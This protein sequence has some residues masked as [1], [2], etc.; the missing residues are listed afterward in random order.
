MCIIITVLY[1]AYN[2][3]NIKLNNRE[4][5]LHS[6]FSNI[7]D[8]FLVFDFMNKRYEYISPNLENILG[9]SSS[10]LS[11]NIFALFDNVL[12]EQKA[13]FI[14]LFSSSDVTKFKERI[15]EYYHPVTKQNRWL[16]MRNYPIDQENNI[17]RYIT[18]IKDITKEFQEQSAIREALSDALKA[19][20]SKTEFMCHMSHEIKTPINSILGLTQIVLNSLEDRDKVKNSLEKINYSS[21]NLIDMINNVLDTAKHNNNKLL[22]VH[23]PFNLLKSIAEFSSTMA[24]QAEIKNIE[25]R[26]IYHNMINDCL[27]GDILRI[28]QILGNCLSNAI[29]FTATGGLITLEIIEIEA[30]KQ[31][32]LYRFIISDTGKGMNADYI[33][34]IFEPFVQEN[35]SIRSRYGGSGFGMTIVKTLLDLMG[36]TIRIMSKVDTGTTVTIDIR[37]KTAQ[38]SSE[39]TKIT[40]MHQ[41]LSK[42]DLRGMRVLVVEDNEINLEITT[43]YLK[44]INIQVDCVTNG[45]DAIKQ[46]QEAEAGYYTAILMDLQMPEINGYETSRLIR[47]C[48]HPDAGKIYILAMTADTLVDHSICIQNG[49]NYHI[50]KPINIDNFY[51]ILS[52]IKEKEF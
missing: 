46:F 34:H 30:T 42:L 44:N 14:S 8:V 1:L 13:E 52:A 51:S 16:V 27:M 12:P 37:L 25:Y 39:V 38:T 3:I 7:D 31:D 23:E 4:E 32:G 19:N 22:L 6:L 26:L 47:S 17:Y 45:Y 20:E 29:K 5:L 35:N 24:S 18:S 49:M 21:R 10:Q 11:R 9:I 36:G 48:N 40:D 2:Q 50:T 41:S 28:Q 15:F 33:N 43:E